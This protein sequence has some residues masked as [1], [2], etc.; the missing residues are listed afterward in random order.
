MSVLG[1]LALVTGAAS[2]I[3]RATCR[4]LADEGAAIIAADC[5][6][7]GAKDTIGSL[8]SSHNNENLA[9]TMAVDESSSVKKGLK[10]ILEQYSKPPSIVVNCA[11]ITRDNFLLK[12]SEQD[13]DDVIR[14]NLKGTFLV[15][16]T[17]A[18]AVIQYKINNASFI[19]IASIVGKHGNI[20]QANY[21]ASKAGVELLTKT[22]SKEFGKFGIRCNV[23]LPGFTDTPMV[24]MVPEKVKQKL[25]PFISAGRFGLPE[26]IA[27]TIAFLASEKSSYVNGA[28][29]EV[30]GGF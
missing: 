1:K 2:G 22:A 16:Q 28:S 30:T 12:M 15:M 4:I 29:I 27:Q 17:F 6:L 13:F 21:C 19:N 26:E 24:K 20:G 9:L 25:I 3:G 10:L 11:G 18:N 5:N 23:I 7:S 8:K 14:V